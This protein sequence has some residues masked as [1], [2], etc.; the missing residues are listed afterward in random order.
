MYYSRGANKAEAVREAV[1]VIKQANL[2]PLEVTSYG[3]FSEREENG[4]GI[5]DEEKD[6]MH[7]AL[8]ENSVLIAK[9]KTLFEKGERCQ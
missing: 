7:R 6:L 8:E 1:A 2:S 5:D 9:M 4:A 3:T